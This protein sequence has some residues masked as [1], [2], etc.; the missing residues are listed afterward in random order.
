MSVPREAS[1]AGAALWRYWTLRVWGEIEE[2]S[3]KR[4]FPRVRVLLAAGRREPSPQF[5]S[6]C[7][8]AVSALMRSPVLCART[9][10]LKTE[11]FAAGSFLVELSFS[12]HVE[13]QVREKIFFESVYLLDSCGGHWVCDINLKDTESSVKSHE[14]PGEERLETSLLLINKLRLIYFCPVKIISPICGENIWLRV[15]HRLV[16]W[17]R[18]SSSTSV[19]SF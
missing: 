13:K 8:T 15:T 17:W 6:S 12:A 4:L 3:Q 14:E 2:V 10:M 16:G 18:S 7:A 5:L 11:C 19:N 9:I 1:A